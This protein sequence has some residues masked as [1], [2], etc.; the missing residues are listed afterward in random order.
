MDEIDAIGKA[1]GKSGAMGGGNDERESTLNQLLVEM[2][3][4]GSSEHVVVLAGTNRSDVLDPALLRPGRF[5]R[6]IHIDLPDIKGR[7]EVF[8]VHLKPVTTAPNEDLDALAR[9]L[10]ALTPGFSGADVANVCNEAALIAAR[11]DAKF[12]A[13][14]HFELAIERVVG[15]TKYFVN[16]FLFILKN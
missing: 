12:V 9:K 6:H 3:G 13:R 2:D 10:A 7:V 4:F 5:D 1:R 11:F 14:K 8:L 15:G 16:F